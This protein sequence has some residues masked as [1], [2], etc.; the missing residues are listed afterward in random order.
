[1]KL[2]KAM[3]TV[4]GLTGISRILGFIRD[5]MTAIILG[6][7]PV[8]DA[9]IVALKLPNFFRRVTAE[10]AFTVSFV[11]MYARKLKQDGQGEADAFAS[12]SFAVMAAI[13]APF[14]VLAIMA[15]PWIIQLLAPGF[16]V[17]EERYALAVELTR[18][19]FP[20]LL[21]ISLSALM[22]GV[23]NAH[24]RF[25]PF[26]A[27]P[28]VF[29]LCLIA[30][31]WFL[32][33]LMR[34][35]GH[36]LSWGLFAAGVLQFIGLLAC[37]RLYKIKITF[38]RPKID[39]DIKKLF[40]LMVPGIIGAGVVH[41]NLFVDVIIASTLA[42]GSISYLY[43]AD[44]LNQLPLGI[45]GI[46]VGTALLPMLSKAISSEERG[47][48]AQNLFNRALEVC[49]LLALPA[50][51]AMFIAAGPLIQTLFQYGNFSA[52]DAKITAYVLMGYA[53]GVP[54]YVCAKVFSTSYFARQ[55]TVTPVRIAV[56]CALTNIGLALIL[57]QFMGVAGIALSTGLCGWLQFAMLLKGLRADAK[58][59]FD[60]RFSR[61]VPRLI[62]SSCLMA[63]ALAIVAHYSK[64]YYSG[65]K[66][67]KIA[68]L[69][70]LVA[71]GL[72]T[73]AFAVLATGAIRLPELKSLFVRKKM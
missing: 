37:V 7:G 63:L 3:A 12:N 1:M 16:A 53:L 9:F 27:A 61:R 28:I 23:L 41:I 33:P 72:T 51:V 8:A 45:V 50:G 21:L 59:A 43:Y 46:A 39:G 67:E 20:Y 47:E 69:I 34:T 10:G 14:T 65:T 56:I 60:A 15:M 13:L 66:P 4:G 55:D 54:A 17:G 19:T 18:V 26:A 48:E 11:P 64:D 52:E 38:K 24:D 31:L 32:E 36:A 70:V 40:R 73:Y 2:L 57:I 68:A 6:A 29:N 25:A 35:G 30:A 71:S 44:R 42:T 58:T 49:L 62:F 22:G 5:V